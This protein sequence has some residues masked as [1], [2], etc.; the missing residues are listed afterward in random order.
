MFSLLAAGC[1]LLQIRFFDIG[2][3]VGSGVL[4]FTTG[5]SFQKSSCKSNKVHHKPWSSSSLAMGIS[6]ATSRIS[7][8]VPS[9]AKCEELGIRE[10]PQQSKSGSWNEAVAPENSLVRYVLEGKGSLEITQ[11][12]DE[13]QVIQV[14]PG[15]LVEIG[16]GTPDLQLEWTSGEAEMI[17]LTPGFEE[18]S[19][20]LG[21]IA[22]IIVLFGVLLSGALG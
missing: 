21:V 1:L 2:G 16:P 12:G 19:I 20:F 8:S 15:S 6:P 9:Q 18:G 4:A 11:G 3:L 7:I 22:G 14:N 13:S 17:L 10:W 5:P